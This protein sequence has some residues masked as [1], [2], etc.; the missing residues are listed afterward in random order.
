MLAFHQAGINALFYF[1]GHAESAHQSGLGWY[2]D[3]FSYQGCHGQRHRL[4]VADTAL[5]E[6][7]LSHRSVAFNPI[8]IVHAN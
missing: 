6:H 2:D 4:I 8:G 5:H 7:F 3:R 1:K